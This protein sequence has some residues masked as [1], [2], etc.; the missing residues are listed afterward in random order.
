M[1]SAGA[2]WKG[3]V[4]Q[5]AASG[6]KTVLS[7]ALSVC[8]SIWLPAVASANL[9]YLPPLKG[10]I[11]PAGLHQSEPETPPLAPSLQQT[12]DKYAG[13][14]STDGAPGSSN[15]RSQSTSAL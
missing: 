2:A 7:I 1:I 8:I 13:N 11:D 10:K 9:A 6:L 14:D 15:S 4:M 3:T 12:P 5:S